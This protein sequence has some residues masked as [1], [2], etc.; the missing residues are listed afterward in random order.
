MVQELLFLKYDAFKIISTD[1]LF[2]YKSRFKWMRLNNERKKVVGCFGLC[3][4]TM[5]WKVMKSIACID[6]LNLN[7]ALNS[8]FYA[9]K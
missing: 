1:C 8:H 9:G 7:I 5:T 3:D 4:F 6:F 2:V